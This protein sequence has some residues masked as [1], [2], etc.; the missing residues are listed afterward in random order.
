MLAASVSSLKPQGLP[1][2]THKVCFFV[3]GDFHTRRKKTNK[4]RAYRIEIKKGCLQ[5]MHTSYKQTIKA[6]SDMKMHE[7]IRKQSNGKTMESNS[8]KAVKTKL[9]NSSLSR[10]TRHRRTQHPSLPPRPQPDN[11]MLH[12]HTSCRPPAPLK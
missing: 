3:P 2:V 9:T 12:H 11:H 7:D 1:Q 8:K 6:L 4:Q 5:S 10:R